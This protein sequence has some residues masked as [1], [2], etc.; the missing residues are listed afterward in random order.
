MNENIGAKL[1]NFKIAFALRP[2]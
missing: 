2:C 1:H